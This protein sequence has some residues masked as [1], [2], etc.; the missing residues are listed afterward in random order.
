MVAVGSGGVVGVGAIPG[1]GV[2]VLPLPVVGVGDVVGV[3]VLPDE[4]GPAPADEVG[5]VL[6]FA[7]EL[8]VLVGRTWIPGD[9][10]VEFPRRETASA[11]RPVNKSS[12]TTNM[13]SENA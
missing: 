1:V 3:E 5:V 7:G 4:D 12:T 6:F 8:F 13:P 10:G 9:G 11:N 2:G